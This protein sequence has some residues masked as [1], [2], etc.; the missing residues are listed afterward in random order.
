[1]NFNNILK[2]KWF[3]VTMMIILLLV[4]I[5]LIFNFRN[6]DNFEQFNNIK[7]ITISKTNSSEP[8]HLAEIIIYD[9]YGK[10]IP[11]SE[12]L[13][14]GNPMHPSF[15]ASNLINNRNDFAHTNV[16]IFGSGSGSGYNFS[17]LNKTI[18]FKM[19]IPNQFMMVILKN[20]RK[21]SSIE[22]INRQDCCKERLAGS[23]VEVRNDKNVIVYSQVI[24]DK[25]INTLKIQLT[26]PLT[27]PAIQTTRPPIQTTRPPTQPPIQTTQP[28]IQTTQPP[29]RILPLPSHSKIFK[30]TFT[31]PDFFHALLLGELKLY[32]EFGILIP[33]SETELSNKESS[34]Q[35]IITLKN[36]KKL[37]LI[38]VK[39]NEYTLNKVSV[40]IE[41]DKGVLYDQTLMK[42]PTLLGIK[43]GNF[44]LL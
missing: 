25:S 34:R 8:I 12:L 40:K 23:T 44:V 15:P 19:K 38:D 22:I 2:K 31:V 10:R 30:I 9:E 36:P 21:V 3:Q 16:D 39:N 17:S 7:S 14:Q 24:N 32:D 41:G 13:A 37:S 5:F 35:I 33:K 18:S 29:P 11:S 28:P 27:R 1:M 6:K 26:Q 20:P 43:D 42:S 4:I